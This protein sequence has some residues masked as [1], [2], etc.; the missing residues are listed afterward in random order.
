MADPNVAV[1]TFPLPPV[2][3][4]GSK[5]PPAPPVSGEAYNLFG[6]TYS[7]AAVTPTLAE[8]KRPVLYNENGAPA[9]EL[10][11]LNRRLLELF[12]SLTRRIGDLEPAESQ[13]IV[14]A[15][16]DVM[17]NMQHI[18]NVLR[19]TRARQDIR[20]LLE[21]QTALRKKQTKDLQEASQQVR[22]NVAKALREL[23]IK[24]PKLDV[25]AVTAA[26]APAGTSDVPQ[27]MSISLPSATLQLPSALPSTLPSPLAPGLSIPPPSAGILSA[28]S[29]ALPPL[30]SPNAEMQI[31]DIL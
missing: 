15:I 13:A 30:S 1:T 18:I 14:Q 3:Y 2:R 6:E 25:A 10:R 31:E 21:R 24:T 5:V 9:K 7:V 4:Y 11:K 29:S 8:S 17:I 27:P 12:V 20:D 23:A 26:T 28:P 16:E 19:P 22:S